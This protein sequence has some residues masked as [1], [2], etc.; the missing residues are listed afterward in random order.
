M[1]EP[2]V[3][4]SRE[5]LKTAISSRVE[6]IRI[7]EPTIASTIKLLIAIFNTCLVAAVAASG[8]AIA[9][10]LTAHTEVVTAP[11][12]GLISTGIRF[13]SGIPTIFMIRAPTTAWVLLAIGVTVG[14]VAALTFLYNNY[15]ITESRGS[16]IIL[17]KIL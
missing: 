7:E 14:G 5:E 2:V 13:E 17:K 12:T 8:V 3:V 11:L 10:F 4:R 6:M 1:S 15:R 16:W 9:A